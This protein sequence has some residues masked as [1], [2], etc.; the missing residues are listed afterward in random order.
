M[1]KE[2][3]KI[4]V[5]SSCTSPTIIDPNCIC[6]YSNGYD[7]I[8]LEFEQCKCCGHI[9]IYPAE[10]DFNNEQLKKKQ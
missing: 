6:C 8:E 4:V 3:V 10:T 2:L 7:T 9:N 5:C 1:N